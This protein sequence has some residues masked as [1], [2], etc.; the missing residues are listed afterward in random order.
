MTRKSYKGLKIFLFFVF[1]AGVAAIGIYKFPNR[2]LYLN[3][4]SGNKVYSYLCEEPLIYTR[5]CNDFV[6]KSSKP[7]EKLGIDRIEI[8]GLSKSTR[9]VELNAYEMNS[10]ITEIIDGTHCVTENGI[11][12]ITGNGQIHF[13]TNDAFSDLLRKYSKSFLEERIFLCSILLCIVFFLYILIKVFQER[14]E[15]HKV[16]NHA[17]IAEV[18]K[19]IE[20][21]K[22]YGFYM[23]YSAQTDLRAEVANSYLN[24]LWW[25]LEPMFNMLVYVIVFGKV[26]GRNLRNYSTFIFCALLMFNFFS[27]VVNYSVKLVRNNGGIITKVYIPK[28]VLLLSNMILNLIKLGFSLLVLIVMLIIFR[29]HI[30]WAI[31]YVIP[32]YMVLILL[33]FGLGM[34]LLHFGVYIDDLSYAVGIL[35]TMLMF[36]SGI[37]YN[38]MTGLPAPLNTLLLN[39]NP[40]TL[41]IDCM[42]NALL[43]NI[44]SNVPMLIVWGVLGFFL[45]VAGVHTVYKNENSYVKVI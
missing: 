23:V 14:K 22:K 28:F 19:F 37:F 31:L 32:S 43:Y 8:C 40:V 26:M 34:I 29:V 44:V 45:C 33:S 6:L 1:L 35:I 27:H 2:N 25:L 12:E 38:A 13:K 20:H 17:V 10:Y 3:F 21:I 41:T 18:K 42:R 4:V 16:N 7:I 24:R 30:G 11:L 9:V 36:L 15:E 39:I 5:T